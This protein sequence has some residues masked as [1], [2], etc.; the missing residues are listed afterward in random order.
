MLVL[1]LVC[2]VRVQGQTISDALDTTDLTWNSPADT[3]IE[4]DVTYDGE[5]AVRLARSG[6]GA[7]STT[8]TGPARMSLKVRTSTEANADWFEASVGGLLIKR[9]SGE[10]PWQTL[11]LDIPGGDQRVDLVY[12][13]DAMTAHGADSVWVDAVKVLPAQPLSIADA[14][15][16]NF[17]GDITVTT[18]AAGWFTTSSSDLSAEDGDVLVLAPSPRTAT[19]AA[20]RLR[21]PLAGRGTLSFAIN[22]L[23]TGTP[24]VINAE[25]PLRSVAYANPPLSAGSYATL[26]FVQPLNAPVP[27]VEVILSIPEGMTALV[28]KLRWTPITELS[29]GTALEAEALPWQAAGGVMASDAAGTSFDG[30]DAVTFFD[31]G[32]WVSLPVTGPAQVT[33]LDLND[34][35]FTMDGLPRTPNVEAV[36]GGWKRLSSLVPPGSRLLRWETKGNINTAFDRFGRLDTVT[37]T[38]LTMVNIAEAVDAPNLTWT[39]APNTTLGGIGNGGNAVEGNDAVRCLVLRPTTDWVEGAGSGAGRLEFA[40]EGAMTCALNDFTTLSSTT[41]GWS[42]GV[43]ELPAGDWRMRWATT[44]HFTLFPGLD[45]VKYSAGAAETLSSITECNAGVRVAAARGQRSAAPVE[46]WDGATGRQLLMEGAPSFT[47]Q[48]TG[49]GVVQLRIWGAKGTFVSWESGQ[50]TLSGGWQDLEIPLTATTDGEVVRTTISANG[51]SVIAVDHI[52][53]NTGNLFAPAEALDTPGVTWTESHIGATDGWL[54]RAAP[55]PASNPG[56]SDAMV[57]VSLANGAMA[58]L[59]TTL[60]GP[61]WLTF[62][63]GVPSGVSFVVLANGSQIFSAGSTSDW[64]REFLELPASGPNQI[65]FRVSRTGGSGGEV[66]LNDVGVLPW[67]EVSGGSAAGMP[68]GT[69]LRTSPGRRF[70]AVQS[71]SNPERPEIVAVPRAEEV[72]V[73]EWDVT[74]PGWLSIDVIGSRLLMDGVQVQSLDSSSWRAVLLPL[75]AGLHKLRLVADSQRD[76]ALDNFSLQSAGAA[77]VG[78]ALDQPAWNWTVL[79]PWSASVPGSAAHDGTD[80]LSFTGTGGG[81]AGSFH[82]PWPGPGLLSY[83]WKRAGSGP[84]LT[85]TAGTE[86]RNDS[87]NDEWRQEFVQLSAGGGTELVWSAAGGQPFSSTSQLLVDEVRLRSYSGVTLADALDTPGRLWRTTAVAWQTLNDGPG[88]GESADY[89]IAPPVTGLRYLETETTLPAWVEYT[90]AVAGGPELAVAPAALS[91]QS[92]LLQPA[93][94][95]VT[96]GWVRRRVITGGTGTGMVRFSPQGASSQAVLMDNVFVGESVSATEALDSPVPWQNTPGSAGAG[97]RIN[98]PLAGGDAFA[99]QTQTF[100]AELFT[101]LTGPGELAL[102]WATEWDVTPTPA[103]VAAKVLLDDAVIQEITFSAGW[104]ELRHRVPAGTHRLSILNRRLGRGILFLDDFRY[105]PGDEDTVSLTL[106]YAAGSGSAGSAWTPRADATATGGSALRSPDNAP[107]G[108]VATAALVFNGAGSLG[109]SYQFQSEGGSAFSLLLDGQPFWTATPSQGWTAVTLPVPCARGHTLTL[110]WQPGAAGAFALM[111]A[112]TLTAFTPATVVE[113]LD[114]PA[115]SWTSKNCDGVA[116]AAASVVNGDALRMTAQGSFDTESRLSTTVTGPARLSFRWYRGAAS[117]PPAFSPASLNLSVEGCYALALAKVQEWEEVNLDI[118]AGA[119]MLEWVA[120]ASEGGDTLCALVDDVRITPVTLPLTLGAALDTPAGVTV[121]GNTSVWRLVTAPYT[122]GGDAVI[123]TDSGSALTFTFSGAGEFEFTCALP[124]NAAPGVNVSGTLPPNV[125]TVW[126][127]AGALY[128][129]DLGRFRL[130]F[131]L[132]GSRTVSIYPSGNG[133]L[134]LVDDVAWRVLTAPSL[135]DAL[136]T[137]GRA[138]TTTGSPA[139]QALPYPPVQPSPPADDVAFVQA[140]SIGAALET[141]FTAPHAVSFSGV[142]GGDIRVAVNGIDTGGNLGTDSV[143]LLLPGTQTL[144]LTPAGGVFGNGLLIN[145]AMI[146][147]NPSVPAWLRGAGVNLTLGP[148]LWR[149][150]PAGGAVPAPALLGFSSGNI[151][152]ALKVE[153]EGAG[154]LEFYANGGNIAVDDVLEFALDTGNTWQRHRLELPSPGLHKITLSFSSRGVADLRWTAGA[155]VLAEACGLSGAAIF[156]P[157]NAFSVLPGGGVCMDL[158]PG[159]SGMIAVES[160]GPAAYTWWQQAANASQVKSRDTTS[161]FSPGD[162]AASGPPPAP[163]NG[164]SWTPRRMVWKMSSQ[165]MTWLLSGTICLGGIRST[166][167]SVSLAEALDL[168]AGVTA[169]AVSPGSAVGQQGASITGGDAAGLRA[170]IERA[171]QLTTNGPGI[172]SYSANGGFLRVTVGSLPPVDVLNGP[173]HV[174]LGP[175]PQT[176][177]FGNQPGTTTVSFVSQIARLPLSFDPITALGGAEPLV[178]TSGTEPAAWPFVT[179]GGAEGLLLP[180]TESVYTATIGPARLAFRSTAGA[181]TYFTNYLTPPPELSQTWAAGTQSLW[182]DRPGTARIFSG[183]SSALAFVDSLRIDAA[184]GVTL[185]Q[186]LDVTGLTFTSSAGVVAH[187]LP[188]GAMVDGDAAAF[189]LGTAPRTLQTAVTGPGRLRFWWRTNTPQTDAITC[190]IGGGPPV[191]QNLAVWKQADLAVPAGPQ[192]VRWTVAANLASAEFDRVEFVPE[193]TFSTWASKSVLASLPTNAA[194]AADDS[195]GDGAAGLLEF[196]FGLDP[197]AADVTFFAGS[198]TGPDDARGL[199]MPRI[200]RSLDGADYLELHFARRLNS[201]L[202]YQ[203]Q[204]AV[205]PAGSWEST[206]TLEVLRPLG[207]DWELCRTRDTVPVDP[208]GPRRFVRLRVTQP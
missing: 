46:G 52:S 61:G 125:E 91:V 29:I 207:A 28:D 128:G 196:A 22:Y 57:V 191:S 3:L 172:L 99:L 154:A 110:Q 64:K 195:D 113:A 13:K 37:V 98:R 69:P 201:G 116:G 86:T 70:R 1:P 11:T 177:Y 71:G 84:L 188:Q 118:P 135:A 100:G 47:L 79:G 162:P 204:G 193:W 106:D 77:S 127:N 109:F 59:S 155:P 205:D 107:A 144:R 158:P 23:G 45:A 83:W 184:P 147:P 8:L 156:V 157:S 5:D 93:Q 115:R 54:G 186:A 92:N 44:Y 146:T 194:R 111:D 38:P 112:V 81:S 34:L 49:R 142:E 15:D 76:G 62:A 89:A 138:W 114:A 51:A 182:L 143:Y 192:N 167:Q 161:I 149:T 12:R 197:G 88:P 190:T 9:L 185:S 122:E 137:P 166:P 42:R 10:Q 17:P 141:I 139:W 189:A 206:G 33:W 140:G 36:T 40:W 208:A 43:I 4:N 202:S 60:T 108:T 133:H 24:G 187:A 25:F 68:D 7:L 65:T 132:P 163:A 73:L 126:R 174:L 131:A 199:P 165:P 63:R 102:R 179:S 178:V 145:S 104:R 31:R 14:V 203:M 16:A 6:M 136:D 55:L 75:T 180:S 35:T 200:G 66:W 2:A 121:N 129:R 26:E 58:D 151:V 148:G 150:L 48:T 134:F 50:A 124:P 78:E 119:R 160:N 152:P 101:T 120:Y 169:A 105:T 164:L 67:V 198:L 39:A 85:F 181:T 130:S 53:L 90:T 170:G 56:D 159:Q 97:F 103:G 41:G 19:N 20:A 18:V 183:S 94:D 173:G 32:A 168:P 176:V 21:L 74:G 175:G 153:T 72:A 123:G 96:P 117:G 171:L 30:E 95:G 27:A 82:T 87:S 80:A